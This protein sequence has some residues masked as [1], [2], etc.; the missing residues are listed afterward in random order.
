VYSGLP[1]DL[2]LVPLDAVLIEQVFV[3]LLENAAKYTPKGSRIDIGA[4][5][6]ETEVTV[7]LADAGPGLPPEE[8]GRIFDKFFRGR[9]VGLGLAIC[10]AIV[11]AHGGRIWASNR[12]GGGALFSLSLPLQTAPHPAEPQGS[13]EPS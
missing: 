12:P 9:G 8:Q 3:N 7:E 4:A 11:A 6:T 1:S 13:D 2:P 5:W 10:H